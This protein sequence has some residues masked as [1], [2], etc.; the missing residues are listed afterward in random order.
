[1]KNTWKLLES[2]IQLINLVQQEQQKVFVQ[3]IAQIARECEVPEEFV[4]SGFLRIEG[5]EFIY[6]A[7]D[8]VE[9]DGE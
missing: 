3:Y 1:M 8:E 7:P 2:Q 4:N 5:Q 9:G 6:D